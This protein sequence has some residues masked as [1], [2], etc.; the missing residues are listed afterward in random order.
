M[1]DPMANVFSVDL[2]DWYQG[3]EI[4]MDEWGP[5]APRL[6]HGLRPLLED[7]AGAERYL[8]QALVCAYLS[9]GG[10]SG[11]PLKSLSM[12]TRA[13]GAIADS[14]QPELLTRPCVRLDLWRC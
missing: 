2:E 7:A 3:L 1:P 8:W 13:R 11:S 10:P 5:Y 14:G 12:M 9:A 6:E 4:D